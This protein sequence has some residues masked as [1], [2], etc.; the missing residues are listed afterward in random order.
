MRLLGSDVESFSPDGRT[1]VQFNTHAGFIRKLP[2]GDEKKI[3]DHNSP[4]TALAFAPDGKILAIGDSEGQIILLNTN[5]WQVKLIMEKVHVSEI[6]KLVFSSD[7]NELVSVSSGI[8]K[9]W[10]L[11]NGQ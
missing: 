7:G 5:D 3:Y 4:V 9:F 10:S 8:I 1:L 6:I 2:L 11:K